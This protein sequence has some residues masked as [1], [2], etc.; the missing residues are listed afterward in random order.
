MLTVMKTLFDSFYKLTLLFR[1]I[2]NLV[3]TTRLEA[4][5]TKEKIIRHVLNLGIRLD[6][7][8]CCLR[9]DKHAEKKC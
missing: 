7:C 2:S 5:T 1:E 4:A 9:K 3:Y 6:D 8:S